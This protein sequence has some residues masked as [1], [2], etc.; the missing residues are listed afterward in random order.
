MENKVDVKVDLL[1]TRDTKMRVGAWRCERMRVGER[2]K[3]KNIAKGCSI[4]ENT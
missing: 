1:I 4:Y 2:E 3:D